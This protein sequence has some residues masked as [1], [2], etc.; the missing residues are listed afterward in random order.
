[1]DSHVAQ[2]ALKLLSFLPQHAT[3]HLLCIRHSLPE[4]VTYILSPV[5]NDLSPLSACA[6]LAPL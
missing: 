6:Q 5:R 1:M 2:A 3:T 4:H